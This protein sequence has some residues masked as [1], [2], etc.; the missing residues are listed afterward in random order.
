MEPQRR[1]LLAQCQQS[2]AQAMTEVEAVLG[3]LEAAG[4]LSPVER[5]QLDEEAGGAKAELLL[6]LL[7][8]KE[9]DHFQD[10]RAAL[11]KTQPHLLPILYLN[12][13]VGPPQST[14]GA[15]EWQSRA[16]P[17]ALRPPLLSAAHQGGWGARLWSRP[18][19]YLYGAGDIV[20]LS[21]PRE[22][23][24]PGTEFT[25]PASVLRFSGN[26]NPSPKA[27]SFLSLSLVLQ[28]PPE[29]TR[30]SG[31]AEVGGHLGRMSVS[32]FSKLLTVC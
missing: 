17:P 21:L 14:E 4:A 8:A 11:E 29:A 24:M 18:P 3:L 7:L 16:A 25:S 20:S 6:Q 23:R 9:Q 13:V 2:L 30:S 31:W 1:E 15:G 28:S 27:L 19:L 5:R 32:P 10:L 12:G 26:N 22:G